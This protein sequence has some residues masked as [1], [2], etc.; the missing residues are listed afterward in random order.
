VRRVAVLAVV[1]VVVV[2][3]LV[4]EV[5]A[6]PTDVNLSQS[7]ARKPLPFTFFLTHYELLGDPDNPTGVRYH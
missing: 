6:G 7:G 3:F 2:G 4:W 5:G 1:P